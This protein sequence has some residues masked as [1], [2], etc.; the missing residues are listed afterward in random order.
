M[1]TY[2]KSGGLT[3]PIGHDWK[4]RFIEAY[5]TEIQE[6]INSTRKGEMNGPS[7]WDGFVANLTADALVAS[8]QTGEVVPIDIGVVPEF[9]K[10]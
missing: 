7:A 3:T 6:W 5:D 4:K 8:Q 9:Y 10:K 2:R 1:P